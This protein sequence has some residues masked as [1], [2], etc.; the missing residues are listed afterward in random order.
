LYPI[1]HDA[2]K[3]DQSAADEKLGPAKRAR[4]VPIRAIP[5]V[6]ASERWWNASPITAVLCRF[7]PITYPRINNPHLSITTARRIQSVQSAGTPISGLRILAIEPVAISIRANISK[8]ETASPAIG[9]V[10]PCPYG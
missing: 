4:S 5:V 7:L 9:S 1:N 2:T 3:A 10:F 6:I 8:I